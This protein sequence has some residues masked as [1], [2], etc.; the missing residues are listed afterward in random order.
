MNVIEN[1]EL[2]AVVLL[3][4][5]CYDNTSGRLDRPKFCIRQAGDG[6]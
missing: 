4:K 2:K 6:G 5:P 3:M 1:H